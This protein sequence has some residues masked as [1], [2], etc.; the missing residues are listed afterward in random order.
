MLVVVVTIAALE[1]APYGVAADKQFKT[2]VYIGD[3]KPFI[4]SPDAGAEPGM[5]VK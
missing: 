2:L 3:G 4:L 5:R 1:A